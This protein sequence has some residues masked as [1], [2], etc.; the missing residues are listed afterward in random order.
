MNITLT[1][2]LLCTY[3]DKIVSLA[4]VIWN[5]EMGGASAIF[6]TCYTGCSGTTQ[7]AR[8]QTGG[9]ASTDTGSNGQLRDRQTRSR[10]SV[11]KNDVTTRERALNG[12]G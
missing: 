9:T 2:A 4:Q 12:V 11:P 10:R 3:G 1:C 7:D 8:V 6:K 5:R